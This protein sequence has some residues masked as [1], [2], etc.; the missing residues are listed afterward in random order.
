VKVY[1]VWSGGLSGV[2]AEAFHTIGAYKL[3]ERWTFWV[4]GRIM[5]RLYS[6]GLQ[7]NIDHRHHPY[8]RFDFDIEGAPN[9]TTFE[10]NTTT[11]D[12]G[13]G[14]GWHVKHSEITRVK[15]PATHRSWA[16]MDVNTMRRLPHHSRL[17]RC[18]SG[19]IRFVPCNFDSF[20]QQI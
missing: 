3:T 1:T 13:W 16:V 7:C 12:V 2:A 6:D 8:W 14:P 19:R 9:D 15:N 10:Y 4:D 18:H 20:S 17:Q 5:P 11:P